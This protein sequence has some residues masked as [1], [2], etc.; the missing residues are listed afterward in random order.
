MS[1]VLHL[2]L[3]LWYSSSKR[4]NQQLTDDIF[5]Y[6]TSLILSPLVS[7]HRIM[8]GNLSQRLPA[9]FVIL[10][11]QR[12]SLPH[13]VQLGQHPP[14]HV[15]SI[16][17]PARRRHVEAAPYGRMIYSPLRH[18]TVPLDAVRQQ[19]DDPGDDHVDVYQVHVVVL[20]PLRGAEVIRVLNNKVMGAQSSLPHSKVHSESLFHHLL[21]FSST[22]NSTTSLQK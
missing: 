4:W 13:L 14:V 21:Y 3:F 2:R 12:P 20:I 5:P 16:P 1:H 11:R 9:R 18:R 8:N 19:R 17:H 10:Q 7:S 15:S 6:G 22:A